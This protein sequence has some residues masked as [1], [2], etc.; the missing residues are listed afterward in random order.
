MA[1]IMSSDCRNLDQLLRPTHHMK[2]RET[3]LCDP[4]LVSTS[5]VQYSRETEVREGVA[6][7]TSHTHTQL[8]N[9]RPS[10]GWVW[11]QNRTAWG[12]HTPRTLT[13]AHNGCNYV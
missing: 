10:S 2:G 6:H 8:P 9:M 12:L 1:S 7:Q 5:K 13:H 3:N 4:V 11:F